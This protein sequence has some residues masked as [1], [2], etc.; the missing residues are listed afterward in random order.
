[1]SIPEITDVR[2]CGFPGCDEPVDATPGVG[3]PAGYC[4]NPAH[5]R[6]AAWRARR[7]ESGRVERT[8]EDDKLPVDAA[9]QR[10]SVLRSQVAGMVEHLQQQLVVLVDELRTVAD[11][12]AAEAQIE[13]VTSD[14]AEQVA[15][16][17]ARA[18]RAETA[19]RK[20]EAERAEADAA[21]EESAVQ[22]DELRTTLD[23][24]EQRAATLESDLVAAGEDN[25][26]ATDELAA[27][28]T[29]LAVLTLENVTTV[30][31]L[32]EAQNL[33][34]TATAIKDEAVTAARAAAVQADADEAR[35]ERAETEAAN[36]RALLDQV[37][38]EGE[39]VRAEVLVL[40]G[41]LATVISERD[42]ATA[43]VTRERSYAEQR[44]TD[45]RAAL[46]QQLTQLRGDVDELRRSEREQRT[47][48]DRAEAQT[49]RPKQK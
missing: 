44:V 30:A 17:A 40:N 21:A 7:A 34:T 3:R 25:A 28:T 14:A 35:A 19:A 22:V 31:Q 45:V 6:A 36:A 38:L 47:R 9:R 37:R 20:A 29:Q 4:T 15:S 5:N 26:R 33:V 43:E 23:A 10:A 12:D 13:A 27:L 11:P 39:S 48:A 46:E 1:M 2:T 18:N 49:T 8:V 16:A 32:A 24:L 41:R 42:S